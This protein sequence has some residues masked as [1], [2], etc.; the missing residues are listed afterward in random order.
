L[1]FVRPKPLVKGDTIG[2][3]APSSPMLPGRLEAGVPYLE[4]LGFKVKLGKNIHRTNRFLAGTDQERAQ[5]INDFFKDTEV[6]AILATGGGYGAQRILPLLDFEAMRANPKPLVGFSD[7]TGLNLALLKK[8]GLVSYTGFTLADTQRDGATVTPD[9]LIETTLMNC[10]FGK[11]FEISEGELVQPG[12]AEG[13]LIGGN[14]DLIVA[15]HG[16]PYQPDYRNCIFLVEEVRLEPYKVDAMLSHL[17]LLGI[18]DQVAG[19]IFG[20]FEDCRARFFPDRDGTVDDVIDEWS[21]KVKVPCIKNFPYG[22]GQ[23]RTCLPVGE[24]IILD[25]DNGK[26]TISGMEG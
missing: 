12:R 6:A 21:A 17:F 18:F 22:H 23:R 20:Q 4:K 26:V 13:N 15:L 19:V 8:A 7:I 2:L 14:S 25:A 9:P 1:N 3:Y 11:S 5:D 16:T 24:R 10:L